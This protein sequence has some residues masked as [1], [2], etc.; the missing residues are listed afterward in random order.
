MASQTDHE[1]QRGHINGSGF[2]PRSFFGSHYAFLGQ[3]IGL[4]CI[5]RIALLALP[6]T[7]LVSELVPSWDWYFDQNRL[8]LS[9]I[10]GWLMEVTFGANTCS[11]KLINHMVI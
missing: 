2:F 9:I 10:D 8:S 1:K 4:L 5:F 11:A 3:R 7:R 6:R